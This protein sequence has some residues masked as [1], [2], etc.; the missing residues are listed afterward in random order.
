[1]SRPDFAR[2]VRAHLTN[3]ERLC[4]AL[5]LTKGMRRQAGDNVL[6][7]CPAHRE[8][9][10]SCSVSSG[11]D[12]TVRVR[13]FGCQWTADALGLVAIVH[14]LDTRS[15]F[16]EV[17]VEACRLFGLH[18]LE[19]EITR[20]EPAPDRK[21]PP[22]LPPPLPPPEYAPALEV[23]ALWDAA[24][25]VT[26]DCEAS[27]YLVS[28][29]ID[30]DAVAAANLLRV[31]PRGAAVP[32]WARY[33]GQTWVETGHRLLARLWGADGRCVSL[34]AWRITAGDSPKRLPPTGHRCSGHVLAN[35]PA[36]GMLLGKARPR[37]LVVAEGEPDWTNASLQWP[38]VA[39]VGTGSGWWSTEL[40]ARVPDGCCVVLWTDPD[41][42]GQR[43]AEQITKTLG[44]RV[45]VRRAS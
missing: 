40:A 35:R 38:A 24:D 32:S 22:A 28:R 18:Q 8:R 5:G 11:P 34:R 30:P 26:D 14:D 39:V 6:I 44:E 10:P 29:R 12:G 41:A 16:R 33:R 45:E 4:R 3:P 2:E 25:P 43:Y 42:A 13:C 17:L 21:P 37:R 27:G 7:L 31:L 20:G 36:V 9:S 23:A 15:Q 19:D 1:M